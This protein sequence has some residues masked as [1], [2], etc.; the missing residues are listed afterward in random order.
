MEWILILILTSAMVVQWTEK[1]KAEK[2]IGKKMTIKEYLAYFHEQEKSR[3]EKVK[4]GKQ[5]SMSIVKNIPSVNQNDII[6]GTIEEIKEESTFIDIPIEFIKMY[7]RNE[8]DKART[9]LQ[10]IAY[11]MTD[12]SVS[13]TEKQQFKAMMTYFADCDPLYHELRRKAYPVI[14]GDEGILQSK[15]YPLLPEYNTE[16]IRY[17]LYFAHELG[18]VV[19][20]KKGRSYKLYTSKFKIED[21]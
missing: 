18:D 4:E 15:I 17:V 21:T 11:R 16:T 9:F 20:V 3:K 5:E 6:I 13:E 2:V 12:K 19:R 14:L 10:K 1:K 8:F 7:E